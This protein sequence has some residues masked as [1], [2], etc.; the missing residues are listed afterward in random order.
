MFLKQ[1]NDGINY[2]DQIAQYALE[3]KT[4]IS[5]IRSWLNLPEDADLKTI[6]D[7]LFSK[8][9]D[10]DLEAIIDDLGEIVVNLRAE[11][12]GMESSLLEKTITAN[13]SSYSLYEV[14]SSFDQLLA[15]RTE[16]LS[17]ADYLDFLVSSIRKIKD[18]DFFCKADIISS[19]A[20]E[21]TRLQNV[22]SDKIEQITELKFKIME[23]LSRD[24]VPDLVDFDRF[25]ETFESKFNTIKEKADKFDYLVRCGA[26]KEAGNSLSSSAAFHLTYGK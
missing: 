9:K 23:S 26:I 11:I 24:C 5:E 20:E 18:V 17:D 19:N 15:K 10:V 3:I 22:L 2:I 8:T 25:L 4:F 1:S 12:R 7:A 13:I 16:F 14:L 21:I 6:S